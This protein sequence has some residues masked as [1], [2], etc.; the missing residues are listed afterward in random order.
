MKSTPLL[1][2]TLCLF[3]LMYQIC[4]S[5]GYFY[6]K[7]KEVTLFAKSKTPGD[8]SIKINRATTYNP[9]PAQC[10]SDPL[11]TADNSTID[12]NKLKDGT[13]R[14]VALSRDLLSRWGGCFN[15]GD[16]ITVES[17]SKPQINGDWVVR[18][19]MNA[20]Y[21]KSL[22]FLFDPLNNHPKLGICKDLMIK[23]KN[24]E[25]TNQQIIM[26]EDLKLKRLQMR[27]IENTV[28]L[29]SNTNTS[30]MSNRIGDLNS[31]HVAANMDIE[32]TTKLLADILVHKKE[33]ANIM[34][35]CYNKEDMKD[36]AEAIKYS[37]GLIKM[38]LGIHY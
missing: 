18:D 23:A 29:I 2:I 28:E 32:K 34:L 33:L 19:C 16:T 36:I 22:D 13:L 10:D 20:R 21:K 15:Y 6:E 9:D 24:D 12:L 4:T 27:A 3:S 25:V 7:H 38:L 37:D 17:V 31:L 14:W 11:T 1:F 35:K 30:S 8:K 5:E 26:L